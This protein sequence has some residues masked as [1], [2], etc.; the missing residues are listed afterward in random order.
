MQNA[1]GV[2]GPQVPISG[3]CQRMAATTRRKGNAG[4]IS[5]LATGGEGAQIRSTYRSALGYSPFFFKLSGTID[6]CS[7][8]PLGTHRDFARARGGRGGWR[9]T[10]TSCSE[11][12]MGGLQRVS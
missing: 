6:N 12:V 5:S 1:G 4:D 9:G 11:R 2:F 3:P 7:R 10:L 8:L